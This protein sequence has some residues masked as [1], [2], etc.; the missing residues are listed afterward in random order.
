MYDP[1]PNVYLLVYKLREE[2]HHVYLVHYYIPRTYPN[3]HRYPKIFPKWGNE[4]LEL[5]LN[6]LIMF[7]HITKA[8]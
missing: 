6:I 8:I 1:L 5:L 4:C 2:K 3:K 7:S